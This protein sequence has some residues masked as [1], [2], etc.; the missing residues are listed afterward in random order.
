MI[1]T[2]AR[3]DWYISE[4]NRNYFTTFHLRSTFQ[5]GSR[6]FNSNIFFSV[7]HVIFNIYY[8]HYQPIRN[9]K[10]MFHFFQNSPTI[11]SRF[12]IFIF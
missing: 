3:T 11:L 9:T 7:Q 4:F 6:K 8:F 10:K 1:L 2:V 12:D 5:G